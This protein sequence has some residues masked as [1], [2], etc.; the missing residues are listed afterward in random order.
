[1]AYILPDVT[2]DLVDGEPV[3]TYNR[4][5]NASVSVNRT[6]LEM[7]QDDP[8]AKQYVSQKLSQALW[9]VKSIESRRI[10]I[11]RIV[12]SILRRQRSFFVDPRGD[13]MP[14]RLPNS[15]APSPVEAAPEKKFLSGKIPRR[16]CRYFS[17]IARLTV[18]S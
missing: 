9:V 15:T 13:L 11:E 12:E 10:T 3:C 8:Q 17:L 6:Y 4:Q 14:M 5:Y 1:M 16:H 2:V 18:D 7:A